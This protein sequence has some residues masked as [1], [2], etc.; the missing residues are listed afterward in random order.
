MNALSKVL[1]IFLKSSSLP[2]ITQYH[3]WGNC[4]LIPTIT[5]SQ[6][7]HCSIQQG[8][9]ECCNG[10]QKA[11]L[12]P[13]ASQ[14]T[15]QLSESQVFVWCGGDQGRES[16][17]SA[18][19][20][21]LCSGFKN[22][23]DIIYLFPF[24]EQEK[25]ILLAVNVLCSHHTHKLCFDCDSLYLSGHFFPLQGRDRTKCKII[26]SISKLPHLKKIKIK[27]LWVASQD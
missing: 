4:S 22:S 20:I 21:I 17:A 5:A 18:H 12:L 11:H 7:P 9:R 6:V 19:Q 1:E 23:I 8:D 26:Y 16:H 25:S 2:G 14:Q 10:L 13:E 24:P 27:V 15:S 3:L